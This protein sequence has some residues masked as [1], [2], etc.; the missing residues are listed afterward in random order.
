MNDKSSDYEGMHKD[1]KDD[2]DR[3]REHRKKTITEIND[4]KHKHLIVC[5]LNKMIGKS[6]T[7][8]STNKKHIAKLLEASQSMQPHVL[9][10]NV[11]LNYR[12]VVQI[13]CCH[14][15]CFMTD[16]MFYPKELH[17]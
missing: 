5:L 17:R 16:Y 6:Y 1:L 11:K 2:V 4:G 12:C 14:H 9:L 10:K 13:M 8:H 3:S 15:V 7:T